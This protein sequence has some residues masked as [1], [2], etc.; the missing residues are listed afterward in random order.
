LKSAPAKGICDKSF[1]KSVLFGGANMHERRH[2]QR[3]SVMPNMLLL[4]QSQPVRLGTV[5]DISKG[6][7]AFEFV[8]I[9]PW[10]E[11]PRETEMIEIFDCD[12][13]F[14]LSDTPCRM[15]YKAEINSGNVF[16]MRCGLQFGDLTKEQDKK[17]DYIID[18]YT[19]EILC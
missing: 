5:K 6:G 13:D 15:I 17:L 4:F 2:H 3:Y 7:V 10:K 11:D 19:S 1:E 8:Y 18:N 14:C 12:S 9:T 16:S